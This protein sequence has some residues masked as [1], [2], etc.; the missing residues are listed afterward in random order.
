VGL[1]VGVGEA[2]GV[3]LASGVE[4]ASGV[5]VTEESAPQ[6]SENKTIN[7]IKISLIFIFIQKSPFLSVMDVIPI[8]SVAKHQY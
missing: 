5:G 7:T 1:F 2:S 8:K 4:V 6:A 3:G